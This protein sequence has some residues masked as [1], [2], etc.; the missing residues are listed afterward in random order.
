ME[1]AAQNGWLLL[2]FFIYVL[3]RGSKMSNSQTT[4]LLF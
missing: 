2:S 1:G 3:Q 4:D